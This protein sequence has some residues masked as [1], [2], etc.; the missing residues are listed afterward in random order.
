MCD[1]SPWDKAEQEKQSQKDHLRHPHPSLHGRSGKGKIHTVPQDLPVKFLFVSATHLLLGGEPA[2]S[3]KSGKN[4]GKD[5]EN[6]TKEERKQHENAHLISFSSCTQRIL[7][8]VRGCLGKKHLQPTRECWFSSWPFIIPAIFTASLFL[9]LF[10]LPG[11]NLGK[12]VPFS[13]CLSS[14][15]VTFKKLKSLLCKQD[16]EIPRWKGETCFWCKRWPNLWMNKPRV[17]WHITNTLVRDNGAFIYRA[18]RR[19]GLV[20]NGSNSPFLWALGQFIQRL[21]HY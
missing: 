15:S 5:K 2:W 19:P 16:L 9:A 1:A 8:L 13:L 18:I 6:V 12:F 11:M 17:R 20:V 3:R 7:T 21:T 14:L 4:R 10:L